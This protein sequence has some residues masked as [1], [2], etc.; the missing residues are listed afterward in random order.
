MLK[1]ISILVVSCFHVFDKMTVKRIFFF[2]FLKD[3]HVHIEEQI[4]KMNV[5]EYCYV[6]KLHS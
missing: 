2:F 6:N 3:C 1:A 5:E 4:G